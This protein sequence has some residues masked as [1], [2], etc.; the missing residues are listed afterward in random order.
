MRVLSWGGCPDAIQYKT[1]WRHGGYRS[2]PKLP[3]LQDLHLSIYFYFLPPRTL[4]EVSAENSANSGLS[5][6]KCSCNQPDRTLCISLTQIPFMDIFLF[7]QK[8]SLFWHLQS[9]LHP[10]RPPLPLVSVISKQATALSNQKFDL[11]LSKYIWRQSPKL[12]IIVTIIIRTKR[13]WGWIGHTLRKPVSNITSQAMESARSVARSRLG[14][15][16]PITR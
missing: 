5:L 6:P 16:V 14:G 12:E 15:E 3:C 1:Q 11:T 9:P 10:T 2:D 7:V 4:C 13:K 8:M